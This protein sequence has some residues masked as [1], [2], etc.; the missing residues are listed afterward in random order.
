ME[1]LIKCSE[2]GETKKFYVFSKH[3]SGGYAHLPNTV[4]TWEEALK[5]VQNN[6]E[7]W[8]GLVRSVN[9]GIPE[10]YIKRFGT[11]SE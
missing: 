2:L 10:D 7:K 3:N 11:A 9:A 4:T 8:Q 6:L 1:L 5:E